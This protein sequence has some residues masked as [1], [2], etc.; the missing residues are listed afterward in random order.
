MIAVFHRNVSGCNVGNHFRN[1]ERIVF[2]TFF[3]V[4][5][6][7]ACF[8]LEGVQTTDTGSDDDADTVF[9]DGTF[10]GGLKTGISDCLT[11]SHKGILC[12]QVELTCFLA[13]EVLVGIKT[14]HFAGKLCLE[15]A[16]VEVCDRTRPADACYGVLPGG[17]D[18][19]AQRVDG[20]ET[21]H[22]YSFKFH[23]Y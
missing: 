7:V 6:I 21:C 2:R 10:R 4:H 1:E 14:F 17:V 23:I 15:Q 18:I 16:C 5:S 13:V 22:Y 12:I 3:G 9:I 20:S 8:F 19:V 11:G